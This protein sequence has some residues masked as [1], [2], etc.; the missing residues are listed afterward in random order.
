MA[1]KIR[2]KN[3]QPAKK[4]FFFGPGWEHLGGFI[5]KFWQLNKDDINK[6]AAGATDDKGIMS[7]KGAFNFMTCISL[8]LFGTFFYV[9]ITAGITSILSVAY[10][11]VYFLF[12]IV[13]L[14]DRI[15]LLANGIFVACPECK[16]KYLIPTY[17]C[18]TCGAEHSKL[19]P[20]Q[21]G[22]FKRVCN[23]GTKLPSHFLLKR[24][25]L[26]SKCP[27]PD[28]GAALSNT[29]SVPVLIPIIGGRSSGKTAFI[30]AFSYMFIEKVAPRNGID[31]E[32]YDTNAEEFYKNE[33]TRDF[34]S[35][36]TRMTQ[37]EMDVN[38]ASAKA[39]NF[40]MKSKHFKPSR[41]MYLY[42]IAGESFV[43][44]SENEIQL[45][46]TYCSGIIFML[47]PLSIPTVRNYLDERTNLID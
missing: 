32:F 14:T 4:S 41:V 19:T 24:S 42:D 47:D 25:K 18:P 15:Y 11:F 43:D 28:C 7:F 26:S 30:T 46:Y 22:A 20:G 2:A 1:K 5:K 40:V 34:Q 13:W 21:Y 37:T 9:V 23:C 44:N 33:I 45:Q 31:V 3:V 10:L 35:G 27:N 36:S 39:F 12:F 17:I 16:K 6:R 8:I 38:V 29:E